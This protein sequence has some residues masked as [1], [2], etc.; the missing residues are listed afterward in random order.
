MYLWARILRPY[1][2]I[3]EPDIAP[4]GI[5]RANVL[6]CVSWASDL[7]LPSRAQQLQLTAKTLQKSKSYSTTQLLKAKRAK[8]Q[9]VRLA[10]AHVAGMWK[11]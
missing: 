11:L 5:Y 2:I 1:N 6:M 4:S 10:V 8:W 7:G 3:S 9:N